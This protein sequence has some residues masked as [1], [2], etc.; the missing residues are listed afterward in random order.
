MTEERFYFATVCGDE[1]LYDRQEQKCIVSNIRSNVDLKRNWEN[2]CDLL[3]E[4]QEEL[5]NWKIECSAL[6]N[7]REVQ[8]AE[9]D[10]LRTQLLIF[11]Q[12]KNNDGRFEV[13]Q[14]PP[15]PKGK[16]VTFGD[17]DE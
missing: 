3:N 15:I 13:W 10:K 11:Q 8:Q 12:S 17:S 14:V 7:E 4:Q 16:K 5:E 9:I 6:S 2:V 1:G